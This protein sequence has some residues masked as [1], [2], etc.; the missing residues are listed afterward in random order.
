M[1]DAFKHER[2]ILLHL[3]I[4]AVPKGMLGK[5][6]VFCLYSD[7]APKEKFHLEQVEQS[8][9]YRI[10]IDRHRILWEDRYHTVYINTDEYSQKY[11]TDDFKYRC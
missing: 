11:S 8:Y 7:K 4:V 3:L 9:K 6:M 10:F 5:V 2:Q 1:M